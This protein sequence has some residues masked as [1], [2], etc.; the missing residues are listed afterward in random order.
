MKLFKQII[1]TAVVA[2]TT[3]A[4]PAYASERY[5]AEIFKVGT[6]FCP[7]GSLPTEGQLLEIA[8]NQ[9]LFSL[10][11]NK[12]GGNGRTTFALPSITKTDDEGRKITTCIV[13]QGIYPSRN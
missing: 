7:R 3:L 9:A 2:T 8:K 11:G 10:L 13:V 6:S 5:M 1:A 4:T 12:Y